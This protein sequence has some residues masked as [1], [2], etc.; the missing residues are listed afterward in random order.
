MHSSVE[1]GLV[2][3]DRIGRVGGPGR[4]VQ[5]RSW[6]SSMYRAGQRQAEWNRAASGRTRQGEEGI[7]RA[8]KGRSVQGKTFQGL[9]WS[10]ELDRGDRKQ[11]GHCCTAQTQ[12]G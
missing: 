2:D 12:V 5:S 4:F 7:G 1:A 9:A 11:E 8:T 10:A 3:H 6:L